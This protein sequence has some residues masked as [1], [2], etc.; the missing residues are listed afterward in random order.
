MTDPD[1]RGP[2]NARS[3]QQLVDSYFELLEAAS[4]RQDE[5]IIDSIREHLVSLFIELGTDADGG[6]PAVW[7]K[8]LERARSWG[9]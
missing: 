7:L 6:L 3:D 1:D 8:A 5:L 9:Y 2:E 4:P